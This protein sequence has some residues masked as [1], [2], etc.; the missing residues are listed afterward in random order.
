MVVIIT[1]TLVAE[2]GPGVASSLSLSMVRMH[3]ER[4]VV[5]VQFAKRS[6]FYLLVIQSLFDLS[7]LGS[8]GATF[9]RILS[10][11]LIACQSAYLL[12]ALGEVCPLLLERDYCRPRPKTC[13]FQLLQGTVH[14]FCK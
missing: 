9:Q 11:W 14:G 13:V 12:E 7:V 2:G 4:V 8:V 3:I 5:I 1:L 6:F 10:S